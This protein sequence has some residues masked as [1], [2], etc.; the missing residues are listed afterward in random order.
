[1]CTALYVCKCVDIFLI[2]HPFVFP[3][4][5]GL[6]CSG[7]EEI[8]WCSALPSYRLVGGSTYLGIIIMICCAWRFTIWSSGFLLC[9]VFVKLWGDISFRSCCCQCVFLLCV[10]V[11]PWGSSGSGGVYWLANQINSTR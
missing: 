5:V 4:F 9:T 3:W 6:V 11:L 10:N 8:P 1:M 7:A 2:S